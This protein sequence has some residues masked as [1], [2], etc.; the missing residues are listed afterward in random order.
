MVG[1]ELGLGWCDVF[2]VIN[3]MIVRNF[4]RLVWY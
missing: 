3:V 4:V 2:R 1:V